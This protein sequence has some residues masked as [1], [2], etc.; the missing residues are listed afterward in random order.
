[1]GWLGIDLQRV[2]LVCIGYTQVTSPEQL[3][4]QLQFL[5]THQ[6]LAGGRCVVSTCLECI[7]YTQETSPAPE[8][9]Y[10]CWPYV[11]STSLVCIGHTQA[12]LTTTPAQIMV[13]S[14]CAYTY[15][16]S[17]SLV[18]IGYTQ[19]VLT[20]TPA[21]MMTSSSSYI[22]TISSWNCIP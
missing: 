17:T 20:T 2:Q 13:L 19:V 5:A 4:K 3:Q 15:V 14:K 21:Q 22:M 10:A 9:S 8:S 1:M 6:R 18:C 7:G 12:V 16:V 11:V